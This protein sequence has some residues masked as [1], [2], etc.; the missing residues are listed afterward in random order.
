MSSAKA[1]TGIAVIAMPAQINLFISFLPEIIAK[2]DVGHASKP[3]VFKSLY[4]NSG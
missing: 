4:R 2:F 3:T 1:I